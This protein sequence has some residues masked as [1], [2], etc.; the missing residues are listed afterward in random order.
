[1]NVNGIT[2]L[3]FG[4]LALPG[5]AIITRWMSPIENKRWGLAAGTLG[6]LLAIALLVVIGG[7]LTA[8]PQPLIQGVDALTGGVAS[9]FAVSAASAAVGLLVNWLIYFLENRHE[10][11]EALAE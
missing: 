8:I 7:G 2:I 1:M 11:E 6:G 9:F 3:I 5:G 10:P 4:I